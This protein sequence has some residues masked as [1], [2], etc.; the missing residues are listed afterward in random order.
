MLFDVTVDMIN[1][2]F[3][4]IKILQLEAMDATVGHIRERLAHTEGLFRREIRL[5]KGNTLL[6]DHVRLQDLVEHFELWD[7]C[8]IPRHFR[9]EVRIAMVVSTIT[10]WLCGGR[11]FQR[12][13]LCCGDINYCSSE[14]QRWDWHEHREVCPRRIIR[15][16]PAHEEGAEE[17]A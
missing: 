14:C 11:C 9:F 13:S 7:M 6:Q 17:H 3:H 15:A 1:A 12:M 16:R 2:D 5:V 8:R 4:N 10:C